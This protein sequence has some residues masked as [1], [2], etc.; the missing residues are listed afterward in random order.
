MVLI[1]VMLVGMLVSGTGLVGLV[2][3][4]Q[5]DHHAAIRASAGRAHAQAT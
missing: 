1:V 3:R 4:E 2:G 5:L